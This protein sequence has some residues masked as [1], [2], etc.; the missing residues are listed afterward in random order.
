[1][2]VVVFFHSRGF[3]Q[4]FLIDIF[5]AFSC[6][7]DAGKQRQTPCP[8]SSN[9]QTGT[10]QPAFSIRAIASQEMPSSRP[11]KPSRS[12]VLALTLTQS[13]GNTE[14]TG[15]ARHHGRNMRCHLWSLRIDGRIDVDDPPPSL[16][17]QLLDSVQQDA[18]VDAAIS[19]IG[20]GKMPSDIAQP[21]SAQ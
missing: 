2:C 12:P 3:C 21:G 19:L 9:A 10:F 17:Q 11:T 5:S 18:T 15:D 6:V 14:V 20:I 13:R 16:T 7:T 1:M 4:L 8:R